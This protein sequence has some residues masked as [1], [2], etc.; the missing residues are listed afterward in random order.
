MTG[1]VLGT[2]NFKYW[3]HVGWLVSGKLAAGSTLHTS[4]W[5][6]ALMRAACW[7]IRFN[8]V[9]SKAI[10]RTDIELYMVMILGPSKVLIS[11]PRP[12]GLP[13]ISTIAQW[14]PSLYLGGQESSLACTG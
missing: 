12:L 11:D 9:D 4:L 2:R 10:L 8:I 7:Y 13:E 1:M 6:N 5:T 3:V 14:A